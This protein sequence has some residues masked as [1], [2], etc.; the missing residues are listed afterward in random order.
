MKIVM[1]IVLA[2]AVPLAFVS[3]KA[4]GS[5]PTTCSSCT[6]AKNSDGGCPNCKPR[7]K[8]A[9]DPNLQPASTRKIT[10]GFGTN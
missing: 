1:A 2:I 7:I 5:H 9:A 10:G 3:C 4:G 8:H 6:E